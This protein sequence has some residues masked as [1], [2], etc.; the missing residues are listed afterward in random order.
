MLL[1]RSFD[2]STQSLF[3]HISFQKKKKN[4]NVVGSTPVMVTFIY[5][6]LF[7]VLPASLGSRFLKL[8]GG[9]GEGWRNTGL[10]GWPIISLVKILLLRVPG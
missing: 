4:M 6:T 5:T 1:E 3:Y 9:G 7:W 8:L 2:Y 10:Q